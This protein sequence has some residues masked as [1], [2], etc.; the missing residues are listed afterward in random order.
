VSR[1]RGELPE[2]A[3]RHRPQLAPERQ[4]GGAGVSGQIKFDIAAIANATGADFIID[5]A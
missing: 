3:D 1:G 4:R 2:R 5:G